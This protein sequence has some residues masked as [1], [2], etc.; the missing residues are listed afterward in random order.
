MS[1]WKCEQLVIMLVRIHIQCADLLLICRVLDQLWRQ[2][3]M[4]FK[5][6]RSTT[7]LQKCAIWF[8]LRMQYFI[9]TLH[10]HT[11]FHKLNDITQV[12]VMLSIQYVF[13]IWN[14]RTKHLVVFLKKEK[15]KKVNLSIGKVVA[16]FSIAY[17]HIT[18]CGN[19]ISHLSNKQT[20][21][22]TPFI[23]FMWHFM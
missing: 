23:W 1:V 6:E 16:M 18:C 10:G 17:L 15:D 4:I 12:C 14:L 8:V 22:C 9:W 3:V 5:Q 13:N 7:V 2:S 19:S 11:V 21:H 20:K